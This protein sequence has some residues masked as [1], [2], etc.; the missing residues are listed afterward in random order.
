MDSPLGN[1]LFIT[2][3]GMGLVFAAI[4]AFWALMVVLVKLTARER[5]T[6]TKGPEPASPS[7]EP[8]QVE[9]ERELRQQAAIAAIAVALALEPDQEPRPFPMPPTALVSTWQAVLRARQLGQRGS[10]R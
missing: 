10:V 6:A 2:L 9:G 3:V 5:T 1:A 4:V 8:D 7:L